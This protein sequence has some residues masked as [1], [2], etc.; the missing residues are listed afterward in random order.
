MD[1]ATKSWLGGG[2]SLIVSLV[3][4]LPPFAEDELALVGGMLRDDYDVPPIH[5]AVILIA[6][7]CI[8]AIGRA[9]TIGTVELDGCAD[10]VAQRSDPRFGI[11]DLSHSEFVVK[12]GE[13]CRRRAAKG[14]PP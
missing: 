11:K 12:D 8:A 4:A 7:G 13:I 6:D 3:L 5:S 1:C 10:I 9:G 2:L 14:D